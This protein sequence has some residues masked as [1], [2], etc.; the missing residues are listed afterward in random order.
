MS[1]SAVGEG[2]TRSKL[3]LLPPERLRPTE[4]C[5]PE[6]IREV[7]ASILREGFWTEPILVECTSMIV[8]DGYHRRA[9]ALQNGLTHVPCL[10]ATYSDVTLDGWHDDIVVSPDKVISRGLAGDLYPPKSTRHT[11]L[12]PRDYVCSFPLAM[13]CES[14]RVPPEFCTP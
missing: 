5:V 9:F 8:M 2:V 4:E 13:L 6:R 3:V 7:A 1:H 11:L 12:K 14:Y 10:L